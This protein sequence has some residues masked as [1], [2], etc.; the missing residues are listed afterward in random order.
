MELLDD[1]GP[2]AAPGIAGVLRGIASAR[3]ACLHGPLCRTHFAL[4][5]AGRAWPRELTVRAEVHEAQAPFVVVWERGIERLNPEFHRLR[6]ETVSHHPCARSVVQAGDLVACVVCTQEVPLAV[7]AL[8]QAKFLPLF[9]KLLLDF[10]GEVVCEPQPLVPANGREVLLLPSVRGPM[11]HSD[12][13]KRQWRVMAQSLGAEVLDF[14]RHLQVPVPARPEDHPPA[15]LRLQQTCL[16]IL[17]DCAAVVVRESLEPPL[18]MVPSPY[19]GMERPRMVPPAACLDQRAAF[20]PSEDRV[21]HSGDAV[22]SSHRLRAVHVDLVDA[23]GI[24]HVRDGICDFID[25]GR[26]LVRLEAA[27]THQQVAHRRAFGV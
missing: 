2:R 15:E 22:P 11:A 16:P 7:R 14:V 5:A 3:A 21:P 13:L 26:L 10:G 24:E 1:S 23:A 6:S 27:V 12:A 9:A 25:Q 8:H 20:E 17:R 4:D 19:A 18:G